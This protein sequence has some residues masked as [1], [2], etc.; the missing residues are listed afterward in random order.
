MA[1]GPVQLLVLGFKH[2][3]FQ[4]EIREELVSLVDVMP[5]VLS[6]LG[7]EAPAA[8]QGQAM[9]GAVPD[10]PPARRAVFS[11]YGA[12][13]PAVTLKDVAA[14]SPEERSGAGWPLLRQREAHG[15]GKMVRTTAW[16]YV[17]DVTGEV[18]ELY[19]LTADPW[20][21]ENVAG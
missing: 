6:L 19:D 15:H 17:H 12:G 11:E 10:A 5:T 20:E 13:G 4:G 8:V 2:P 18:D 1:I 9:P 21:L 16:K 7:I 14:L 3:D